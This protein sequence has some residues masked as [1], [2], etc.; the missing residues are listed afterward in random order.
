VEDAVTQ[1]GSDRYIDVCGI[2]GESPTHQLTCGECGWN[3]T[4]CAAHGGEKV[5]Q[6]VE[7]HVRACHPQSSL[8]AE[9]KAWAADVVRG[10]PGVAPIQLVLRGVLHGVQLADRNRTDAAALALGKAALQALQE[11][12]R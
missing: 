12:Q 4:R 1:A 11:V 3:R 2:C 5:K 7:A 8:P 6:D 9:L 10:M